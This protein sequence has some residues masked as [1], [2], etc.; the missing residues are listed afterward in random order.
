MEREWHAWNSSNGYKV[1]PEMQECRSPVFRKPDGNNTELILHNILGYNSANLAFPCYN[2]INTR[3]NGTT[4][5]FHV[6]TT[7]VKRQYLHSVL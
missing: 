1:Q 3:C 2:H 7:E 6:I 4:S 5:S